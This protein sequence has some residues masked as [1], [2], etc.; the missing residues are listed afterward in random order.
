MVDGWTHQHQREA[1][2]AGAV[3]G[4][5]RRLRALL[6]GT[7]SGPAAACAALCTPP[8]VGVLGSPAVACGLAAI[9]SGGGGSTDSAVSTFS[10]AAADTRWAA[11]IA[12]SR[13]HA[14]AAAAF[15]TAWECRDPGVPVSSEMFVPMSVGP[16]DRFHLQYA[17]TPPLTQA[18]RV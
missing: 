7:G 11:H 4:D 9:A 12:A 13:A 18:T 16:D 15:D 1:L 3:L 5:T 2:A 17:M 6:G 8:W 10:P 14:A